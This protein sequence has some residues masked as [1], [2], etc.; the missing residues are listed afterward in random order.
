MI[1]LLVQCHP[2]SKQTNKNKKEKMAL[3]S[4][5]TERESWIIEWTVWNSE[6]ILSKGNIKLSGEMRDIIFLG[7]KYFKQPPL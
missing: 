3:T 5:G 1:L 2:K 6:A 4:L 7:V